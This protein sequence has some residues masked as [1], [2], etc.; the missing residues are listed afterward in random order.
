MFLTVFRTPDVKKPASGHAVGFS[1][2]QD[3]RQAS[4]TSTGTFRASRVG[5]S[6]KLQLSTLPIPSVA[7]RRASFGFTTRPFP[8]RGS[9]WAQKVSINQRDGTDVFTVVSRS[10]EAIDA[11]NIF[12]FAASI[13]V[14]FYD[15]DDDD[16]RT[17]NHL[18]PNAR[19]RR[20]RSG[21][22]LPRLSLQPSRRNQRRR[23]GR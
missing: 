13:R 5:A 23:L 21:D 18:Q 16:L 19:I 12:H 7:D 14:L 22:L 15:H 17:E 8:A 20:P 3:K 1:P 11:Q 4:V 10:G 6:S 9:L 2:K